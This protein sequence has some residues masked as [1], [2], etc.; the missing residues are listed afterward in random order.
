MKRSEILFEM[1]SAMGST[2]PATSDTFAE[3]AV[4]VI[5]DNIDSIIKRCVTTSYFG[6]GG[7]FQKKSTKLTW[8]KEDEGSLK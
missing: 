5:E 1:K 3:A 7:D 2:K 4:K 6:P 8:E